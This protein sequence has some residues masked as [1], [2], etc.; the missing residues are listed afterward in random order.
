MSR[1]EDMKLNTEQLLDLTITVAREAG[2]ILRDRYGQEHDVR[3]KGPVDLVTE[4]DAAAE[5]L[6]ARRLRAAYPDHQLL[7]EEGARSAGDTSDSPYR[8]VIDPLDGTTNFAHGFP[9]FAVSIGLEHLGVPVVGVVYDPMRDELFSGA[10][11][12]GAFLNGRRIHV[13]DTTLLM[14]S[15]LA[16]GF[17][18][19]LERRAGQAAAW[20]AFLVRVQ[21]TRQTGSSALNLC[22]VA[23]GRLDGYWER[24]IAPWDVAAGAVIALEAGGSVTNFDG[25]GFI[26]DDRE[27]VASNGHLHNHLLEVLLQHA[28][29][30]P[31]AP[32]EAAG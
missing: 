7:G 8:W 12:Q 9:H 5:A 23:A 28:P 19:D 21:S 2:A 3:F 30:P 15:M 32:G 10:R 25:A 18:Y 4:A 11:G 13:S 24:G 14:R 22:Y 16:T 29:R 27:V 20:Q 31:V 6:I 17:S 1:E 26:A